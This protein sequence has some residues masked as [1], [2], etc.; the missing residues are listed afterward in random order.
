MTARMSDHSPGHSRTVILKKRD[1]YG[2]PGRCR[3]LDLPSAINH[4]MMAIIVYH[5]SR[6]DVEPRTLVTSSGKAVEATLSGFEHPTPPHNITIL[7][8]EIRNLANKSAIVA[9]PHIVG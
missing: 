5:Q 2:V 7:S 9:I 4:A 1:G 8:L 3:K 6:P